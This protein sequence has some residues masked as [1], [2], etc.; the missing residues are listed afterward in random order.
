M[1]CTNFC[2]ASTSELLDRIISVER[3]MKAVLAS[4]LGKPP[5]DELDES[6]TRFTE[7]A[8][9]DH[10]SP[11]PFLNVEDDDGHTFV[12]ETSSLHA[13]RQA[14][15]RLDN[16]SAEYRLN[17]PLSIGRPLTPKLRQAFDVNAEKK[18]RSWLRAILLSYGIMP[19]KRQCDAFL[20]V[21]FEE[22][23]V[24]YPF[25]HPPTIQRTHDYL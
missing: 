16:L 6:P 15:A 3:Q 12:G 14:E 11:G 4:D 2:D 13:L 22:I 23:H 24:L 18:S 5:A 19:D 9:T 10:G 1:T 21:F 17:S 25:L 7:T 20:R 8:T